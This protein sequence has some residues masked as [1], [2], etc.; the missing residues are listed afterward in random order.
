MRIKLSRLIPPIIADRIGVTAGQAVSH[1]VGMTSL[2]ERN[3]YGQAVRETLDMEGAIVD[4]GCW[5][6][7]T[8]L[9]LAQGL[10]K[11]STTKIHAFDQFIWYS[12][13]DQFLSKVARDYVEGESFVQE[14]RR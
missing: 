1:F 7:S 12:W 5:L 10:P 11:G 8:S 4:L 6:G 9:S 13:M 2:S 3:Y 14:A